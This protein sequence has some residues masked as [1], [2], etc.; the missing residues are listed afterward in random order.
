MACSLALVSHQLSQEDIEPR[1]KASVDKGRESL[2]SRERTR[3]NMVAVSLIGPP[4]FEL[5]GATE[6]DRRCDLMYI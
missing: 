3:L 6:V 1:T 5:S 2:R 4:N